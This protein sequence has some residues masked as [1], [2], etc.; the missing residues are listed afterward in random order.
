MP[1]FQKPGEVY[2]FIFDP[3]MMIL[4][5][6]LGYRPRQQ[7]LAHSAR[8]ILLLFLLALSS[9]TGRAAQSEKGVLVELNFAYTNPGGEV[10]LP[11]NFFDGS[12]RRI[13]EVR[14]EISFESRWLEFVD[15]EPIE[16]AGGAGVQVSSEVLE[17]DNP[18]ES[19]VKVSVRSEEPF[20]NA[21]LF[22]LIFKA[23]ED[24]EPE[25]TVYLRIRA[26]ASTQQGVLVEEVKTRDGEV[27]F[28]EGPLPQFGCFFY[29]H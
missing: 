4:S 1:R 16:E 3:V 22:R 26:T 5:M 15:A 18:G 23:S 19:K 17:G 21:D 13:N 28:A 8:W 14:S 11:V 6:M 12:D 20:P 27:I 25:S 7:C 10:E 2:L 29:M 9:G 24:G